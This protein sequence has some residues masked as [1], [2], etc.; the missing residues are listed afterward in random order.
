[1]SVAYP[2]CTTNESFLCGAPKDGNDA[3]G[4]ENEIDDR[5]R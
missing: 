1:V 2:V 5:S 4:T 3:F